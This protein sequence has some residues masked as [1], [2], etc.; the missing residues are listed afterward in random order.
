MKSVL[1]IIIICSVG[2]AFCLAYIVVLCVKAVRANP[3][4]KKQHNFEIDEN[5]LTI[6]LS[7]RKSKK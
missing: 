6:N 7:K 3:T 2:I 5:V 1:P 4:I